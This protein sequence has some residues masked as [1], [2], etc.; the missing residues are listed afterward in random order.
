M[1]NT[2]R[3]L[4]LIPTLSLGGAELFV[5]RLARA[6]RG[7][8]FEAVVC[9]MHRGGPVEARLVAAG[10]PCVRLDVVRASVRR[11]WRAAA[12]AR[13]LLRGVRAIV[14]EQ[15]ID[16]I[17]TH[18]SDADWLGFLAAR[19][20][21]VPC[22]MTFHNPTLLP[23]N[24]QGRDLRSRLRR[25]LQ[26]RMYRRA[27]A[28]IAVS[29]EVKA[30]LCT[31]SGVRAER[32]HVVHSGIDPRPPVT[33]A[34]RAELRVRHASLVEG[35]SPLLVSAGRLVE[36]KGHELVIETLPHLVAAH[37]RLRLWIAGE[38]PLAGALGERAREL[39]VSD[40]VRWLGNRDDLPELLDL[41]DLFITGTRFEG[42]GLAAAEAQQAGLAVVGFRV[43]GIRDV[44]VDGETGL[45]VPDGDVRA[46]AGAVGELL[47][48]PARRA[49]MGAA[50]RVHSARFEIEHARR[51]TEEIYRRVSAS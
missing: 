21:H 7:S 6:Q 37:P 41:A 2:R 15:R 3:V 17:Q 44:V 50:G 51:A 31:I 16:V 32:V 14:R 30:A 28:L 12:D 11:P 23:Q 33:P 48:D 42:L 45:L 10:V 38:G 25:A 8:S 34:E 47:A 29:D 13:L 22:V 46:L 24:R 35:A 36:S 26:S 19:R 40:H 18:L 39:R 27:S 9:A 49:R 20:E 43:S 4:H 1:T 5:E